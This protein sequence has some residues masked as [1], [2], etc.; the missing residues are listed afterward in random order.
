MFSAPRI[1]STRVWSFSEWGTSVSLLPLLMAI[2]AFSGG[3]ASGAEVETLVSRQ[4]TRLGFVGAWQRQSSIPGGAERITGT[5]IV[6]DPERKRQFAEVV[7]EGKTLARIAAD[8]LNAAG[9]AIGVGEAKRLATL[10]Q[11]KLARRGVT[12]EV[13]EREVPEIRLYV[14]G[15]DGTVEARDAETGRLIWVERYGNPRVPCLPIAVNARY[16]AMASGLDLYVLDALTGKQL[17]RHRF[18]AVPL[19]GLAIVGDYVM[20]V[21]SGGHL[22]GISLKSRDAEPFVAQVAGNPM[23]DPVS[24]IGI[25]RLMWPTSAGFIYA[26]DGEGRPGLAFRFPS[27]GLASSPLA[28][29]HGGIFYT[30]TEK[31]MVYALDG[32]KSGSV[33][34]RVSLGAPIYNS[35][36]IFDSNL[37]L[38]SVYGELYCLD[39][40][41]GELRWQRSMRNAERVI[42]GTASTVLIK[43]RDGQLAAIDT[44]GGSPLAQFHAA[45]IVGSLTNPL[46]DRSYLLT[47]SGTIQCLRPYDAELPTLSGPLAAAAVPSGSDSAAGGKEQPGETPEAAGTEESPFGEQGGGAADPFGGNADDPFGGGQGKNNAGDDP[48]GN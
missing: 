25:G 7:S 5:A 26:A 39:A 36:A 27:K 13:V 34:W 48:F 41:T 2:V 28:V 33:K 37:F 31:G 3:S 23:A 11:Y 29:G 44:A 24:G 19:Q 18:G 22:E 16:V 6:V 30:A 42:G 47:S 9:E 12:A 46:T 8:N 14:G 43:T 20:A 1:V 17:R 15:R 38:I 4:M 10:E 21:C 32:S 40:A 45:N 35:P